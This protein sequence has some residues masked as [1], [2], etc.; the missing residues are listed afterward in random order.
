MADQEI[1]DISIIG[2]GPTGLFAAFYA[3]MRGASARIIDALPALGGQLM[4]LYPEKYIFDV[5]GFPKV[6]AKDLVRDMAAQG[7]Q[8][9][10]TTHLGEIVTGLSRV[11]DD[12]IG[13]FVLE[14]SEGDYPSR[15]IVIAA[16]IGAFEA[17]RLGIDDEERFEEKGLYF[18]VLDPSQF[19]GKKVL[20]VGGGDSAFDWAVNLQGLASSVMLIHRRDGFRAHQATINQVQAL[21]AGGQCELR[22]FWEV[23]TLHGNGRV[24][25]VTIR[26]SKTKEEETFDVDAVIPLLG[27]HSDLG[28]IKEWGLDTEKADIKVDTVMSTN[29]PGIYAAGDITSYPGKLKLIATGCRGGLHRGQQRGALHQPQGEG[30]PGPLLQPRHLRADRGLRRHAGRAGP[31][32]PFFFPPSSG[33]RKSRSSPAPGSSRSSSIPSTPLFGKSIRTPVSAAREQQRREVLH[34]RRVSHH[35]HD[36]GPRL[37]ADVV[38]EPDE[39]GVLRQMSCRRPGAI[40]PWRPRP[41]SPPSASRGSRGWS[42]P[43][44]AR[45]RASG[46]SG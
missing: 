33:L 20:L 39:I 38:L 16:G 8:F 44:W 7:L 5:A 9:G 31:F 41:G 34:P 10:A 28:A 35:R 23:K 26:N 2:G 46:G 17:R 13:H 19:E 25:A 11:E 4:A 12:G 24:E 32:P 14:T 43:A 45:G 22:T 37:I 15:T 21:H 42:G 6:L 1:R 29:V 3:G 18:K 27:F 36:G 40:P 30:E